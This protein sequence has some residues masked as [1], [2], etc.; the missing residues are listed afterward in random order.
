MRSVPSRRALYPAAFLLPTAM[1]A[2]VFAA[3]G[4]APFGTR[5]IGVMDMAHQYLPF[6]YSLRDI[7]AGRASLLYLPS[8]CLGG[9][10][11]GV[12]AYYL[13]SPLDLITCLFPR[14]S[15][16]TAVSIM[17]FIRVGLCGLTM[18]VYAGARHG[19]SW[20]CLV[21]A[22]AYAFM[23]Y[24]LAYSF[25]YLWQD[26]VIL[27]PILALG[28]ARL[29][30][31]GRPWL[32]LAALAA[33]LLLNFYIGYIL[34]IFSVLFFLCELFSVR[35]GGREAGRLVGRFALASLAAGALAAVLLL[36]AVMA[37]SGGKAEFSLSVLTLTLKFD[38]VSLFAKLY[39]GAF[40]YEEIMPD[41]LPQIFTGTVT[42]SLAALYFADR[43]IPRRRR[44][45][46]GVMMLVLVVSFAIEAL[47]L[48]WHALNTPSWYNHR[49][50]FLLSFLLCAAADAALASARTGAR[51]RQLLLPPALC[52][53]ATLLVFVGRSYE[54]V[55]WRAGLAALP[56]SAAVS[57]ALY[58][59]RRPGTGRRVTALLTATLLAVHVG[60]LGVNAYLSLTELTQPASNSA[61]YADYVRRKGEAFARIDT[62]GAYVRVESPV[63]FDQ[64]R[65]EPMLFGYDGVSHYGSTLSQE[66]LVFLDRLGLD[67]YADLW[68][69][70]GPGVTA[71]ADT[72][73]GIRYVVS[74][75]PVRD[76]APV[77]EAEGY[78]VYENGN[79]LP[80]GWT[81]DTAVAA[82]IAAGDCFA[83]TNALYA[84][85]APEVGDDIFLP[86]APAERRL[87]NFT[88]SGDAYTQ[89]E[90]GQSAIVYTLEMPTDG[91]LYGEIDF[92]G[93]PGVIVFVNGAFCASYATAQTNGS[94]YLGAFSAGEAVEVR[95]QAFSD[96]TVEHAAFAVEDA[97][98][99]ARYRDALA[100]GCCAL[101]KVTGAHYTGSFT[102][103]EG[104]ALLVFTIPYDTAWTVLLD[105]VRVEP[106]KVQDCLMAVAVTP[107]AHAVELRYLP[108][109]LVPGAAIS[110]AA[111]AAC[112]AVYI[113]TRRK[114]KPTQIG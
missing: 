20:R 60:E 90:P 104:D 99:L 17:Y 24:M 98:V 13:T 82:D 97:A 50:S 21:P 68:S 7:L 41:G 18:C 62:G 22:A 52:A 85:A 56:I 72:L 75:A 70:Y 110:G 12:A 73:L 32:Y 80:I 87:E 53:A 6:L 2:A 86:A 46:T 95:V 25:N 3:C 9:N 65:C 8:M 33:C 4:L 23:E 55:T 101:T 89:E 15:M 88:A 44:V 16:Y 45:L 36:P 74:D 37:L 81:A 14:E 93:L 114:K 105:G 31:T 106:V 66:S 91:A 35:R 109:G 29:A 34:C 47:D 113:A 112:V 69:M 79:A 39:P 43:S 67:R 59:V 76:Y 92:D 107:G 19:R 38:P 71:A 63:F 48:I 102:S 40:V 111:L 51:T 30:E 1:M 54:F 103:G 108:H 84:A 77:A 100:A 26:C 57:G 96:V 42:L 61:M 11:L 94:L 78:N 83:Y 64:D 49:Y 58:A 10:M 27:L 28:I 5:T